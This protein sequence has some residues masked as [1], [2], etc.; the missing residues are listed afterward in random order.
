MSRTET[1]RRTSV[2]S[3]PTP[4]VGGPQPTTRTP[5]ATLVH[6]RPARSGSRPRRGWLTGLTFVLPSLALIGFFVYSPLTQVV[7]YSFT[8]WNAIDPARSVGL[9]NYRYLLHSADFHTI[10]INQVVLLFGIVVWITVPF[11]VACSLHG[12]RWSNIVRA[13]L[14]VPPLLPPVVVGSIF[15]IILDDKGPLN[16]S[17]RAV[18][19]G[20][21]APEWL[22]GR[23]TVLVA[24][25]GVITW[26]TMGVGVLLYSARLA[27]LPP[28]LTD[29][30][31]IDGAGW[32]E[33]VWHIYRPHLRPV[34]RTLIL[35][36]TIATGVSFFPWILP[37]TGGGPGVSST[38]LDY[39]VWG[40]GVRD[41]EAGLA[42]AIGVVDVILI[43]LVLG[44]QLFLRR[45]GQRRA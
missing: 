45:M 36:M 37:L 23:W 31:L 2:D 40:A 32:R 13:M 21:M 9:R 25:I 19:L 15:R 10:M 42:S 33:V 28:E 43:G 29:A 4:Y 1:P 6:R 26:A 16:A 7:R 22:T 41:G 30:A 8:D 18:G 5:S 14:F 17:L 27:T 35:L 39:Q 12:M 44:V 11:C 38:T 24:I 3:G 34:T 20:A